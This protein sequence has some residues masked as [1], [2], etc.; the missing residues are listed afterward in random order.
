MYDVEISAVRKEARESLCSEL[1]CISLSGY[2]RMHIKCAVGSDQGILYVMTTLRSRNQKKG[3]KFLHITKT[4]GSSIEEIGMRAGLAYTKWGKHDV[5]I[6]TAAQN[7][8]SCADSMFNAKSSSAR[9][10]E[11]FWHIPPKYW[12]KTELRRNILKKFDLFVIV[13]NPYDRVVSEYWY[14]LLFLP[15]P[16]KRTVCN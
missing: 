3:L 9:A 6:R 15:L 4:A 2:D 13:R 11:A 7:A 16:Y 14:V 5:D 12:D 1:I 8:P 10:F